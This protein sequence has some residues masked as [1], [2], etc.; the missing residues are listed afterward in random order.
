MDRP[1]ACPDGVASA[2]RRSVPLGTRRTLAIDPLGIEVG[3]RGLVKG[4]V[5]GGADVLDL[6]ERV[7]SPSARGDGHGLGVN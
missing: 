3:V 7:A 2:T 4:L 6:E 1:R 5:V